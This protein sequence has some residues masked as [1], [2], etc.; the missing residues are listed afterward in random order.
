MEGIS[1][2][3]AHPVVI[4]MEGIKASKVEEFLDLGHKFF[5]DAGREEFAVLQ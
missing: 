1:V 2:P 3:V 5:R 4:A